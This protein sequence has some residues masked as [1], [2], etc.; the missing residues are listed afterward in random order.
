M[1]DVGRNEE[2][3]GRQMEGG[4]GEGNTSLTSLLEL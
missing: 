3:E 2:N 1:G 4:G